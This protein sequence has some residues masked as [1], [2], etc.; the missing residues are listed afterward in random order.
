MTFGCIKLKSTYSWRKCACKKLLFQL[1]TYNLPTLMYVSESL[2]FDDF[3]Q[4]CKKEP[5][6]TAD[7]LMKAFRK[8]DI[9]GDG[10][11]SLDELYKIMN[12]VSKVIFCY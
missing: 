9:N 7:D 10:Y 1:Y 2:M 8:I 4:I 12:A 5:V 11:I 6:T 3:V